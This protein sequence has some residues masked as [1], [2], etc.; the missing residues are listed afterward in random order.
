MEHIGRV[1]RTWV[2][3]W[4]IRFVLVAVPTLGI[5]S[6]QAILADE[7]PA[8][9]GVNHPHHERR[10][11]LLYVWIGDAA[12]MQADRLAVVDFNEHSSNYGHLIS[13]TPL[14]NPGAANNE[15]HHCMM[16]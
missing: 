12:R 6:A 10:E 15:P 3:A 7:T 14:P 4:I 2:R 13:S 16:S 5:V 11:T 8:F 1:T 9:D